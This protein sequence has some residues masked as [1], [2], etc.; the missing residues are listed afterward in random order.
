MDIV[1]IEA[2]DSISGV[3]EKKLPKH[4][5]HRGHLIETFRIDELPEEVRPVM[6]YVNFTQPGVCRGPHEHKER[7][8]VFAIIGPGNMRVILWD[9]R[10]NSETYLKR[11]IIYAGA[12]NPMLV[13]IY[14]GI[15]HLLDNISKTEDSV[16]INY[17]TTLFKGWGRKD[18]YMDEKRYENDGSIFWNDYL[19]IRG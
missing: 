12:D 5:D 6:S 7:I 14:P 2:V 9:N 17:P 10:E 4:L 11:K 19:S 1:S 8:E 3:I 13:V 15:I 16:L 18:E